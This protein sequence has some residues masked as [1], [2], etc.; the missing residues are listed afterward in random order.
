MLLKRHTKICGT[1]E[2]LIWIFSPF[3]NTLTILDDVVGRKRLL[4]LQTR[5]KVLL[6]ISSLVSLQSIRS[7]HC[8]MKSLDQSEEIRWLPATQT[9]E[10]KCVNN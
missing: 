9:L 10:I 6:R 8:A 4:L 3:S 1:L 2:V 5:L 7:K